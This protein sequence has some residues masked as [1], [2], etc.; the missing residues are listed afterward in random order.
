MLAKVHRWLPIALVAAT[1]L[2]LR[3]HDLAVRS[4]HADEANQAVK[5]GALLEHG[6][7]E[8]DP[9]DHHG[10]TLYYASLPI[11]WLRGEQSLAALSESTVRLVPAL[12]GTLSV[13]LLFFFAAASGRWAAVAAAAFLA[14]APASVYY[15]RYFVQETSLLAFFL[16]TV[17][18]TQR[19][20][21]SGNWRWAL[22]AGIG[23]GLMQATKAS[24]PL[25]LSAALIALW[26][27]RTNSFKTT[28]PKR[29]LA[30]FLGAFFLSAA[31]FYSSFGTHFTGLSDAF[32]TYSPA[33]GRVTEGSGHE[34][35]WFYF[36]SL[37]GWQRSGGLLWQQLL[38]S[39]FALVG[40]LVALRHS[41]PFLRG[42]LIYTILVGIALSVTPYKTPWHVIHLVP[43]L[44]VLAAG[45]LAAIPFRSVAIVLA[46]FVILSQ[47]RQTNLAV[48]LRPADVRNPYAYVHS[49]P[50]VRKVRGLAESALAKSPQGA[51]RVISEE[52][53]PLPWYFRGL[54]QVGYW[55]L[56]PDDC[57][58][59]LIIASAANT[60]AVRSRLRGRY[61]E[62]F[63]GLR[64]GF[65]CT[66]FT[67]ETP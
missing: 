53:W 27:V 6:V 39:G 24:A 5:L 36:L 23:A 41:Q 61:R 48:F 46:A 40:A 28:R 42:T 50:D 13:L 12:S 59:A 30:V 20:W 11:A 9:V 67:V 55:S 35:P 49:S 8:F 45:A 26:V 19:W 29:D 7:Y 18:C 34:K 2:W 62:S 51:I 47:W 33:S 16:A 22:G 15:S 56:P 66:V 60:D 37:F 54:D 63:L 4:M 14:I 31:L 65:I 21:R 44:A 1:A 57:D 17:V 10:P 25:F 43:G 52:Y 32:S 3:T 64:P 58:G 38:F